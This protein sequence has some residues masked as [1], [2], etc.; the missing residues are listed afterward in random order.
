MVGVGDV[1]PVF[2]LPDQE[3][4]V[5]DIERF[6]GSWQVLTWLRSPSSPQCT[7]IACG[8]RDQ[9]ESFGE[10][11][12]RVIALAFDQPENLLV[13]DHRHRLRFTLLSDADHA[14]SVRYGVARPDSAEPDHVTMLIGP[15]RRVRR[16]FDVDDA[17]FHVENVLDTL[18]HELFT[19]PRS[20]SDDHG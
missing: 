15:D 1:A 3:G 14:V 13:F 6:A 17:E 5:I 10:L 20:T 9:L 7:A 16:R 8:F 19:T 2:S 4:E 12:C 18:E 11:G